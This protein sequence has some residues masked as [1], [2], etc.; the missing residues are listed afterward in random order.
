MF[1]KK[2]NNKHLFKTDKILEWLVSIFRI[3]IQ[4][5]NVSSLVAQGIIYQT[6]FESIKQYLKIQA[7]EKELLPYA[8]ICV[9]RP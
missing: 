4:R 7:I 6:I 5:K 2:F 1:R 8:T 9:N 3:C